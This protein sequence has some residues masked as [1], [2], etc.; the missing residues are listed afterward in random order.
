MKSSLEGSRGDRRYVRSDTATRSIHHAIGRNPCGPIVPLFVPR[1]VATTIDLDP[2]L[3]PRAGR[4]IGVGSPRSRFDL[5]V[6]ERELCRML[7]GDLSL[8]QIA[9]ELG[10]TENTLKTH[11]RHLY[12]KLGVSTRD[13][14]RALA[15]REPSLWD[16]FRPSRARQVPENTHAEQDSGW[17][18]SD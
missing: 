16:G 6:R 5:T 2:R 9:A 18:A 10:R 11:R 13:E 12:G 17:S 8:R 1:N 3:S 15:V 7:L 14:L 4:V